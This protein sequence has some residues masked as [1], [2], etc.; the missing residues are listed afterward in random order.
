MIVAL[1]RI[2]Q[3]VDVSGEPHSITHGDHDIFSMRMVVMDSFFI[4]LCRFRL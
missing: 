4:R 2:A 1:G 3:P